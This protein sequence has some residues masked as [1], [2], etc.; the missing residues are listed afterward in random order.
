MSSSITEGVFHV[1]LLAF[2]AL[3][4]LVT[5]LDIFAGIQ[6]NFTC[7][8]TIIN[9]AFYVLYNDYILLYQESQLI[10]K[11]NLRITETSNQL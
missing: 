8:S 2:T 4:K 9:L 10:S 7:F 11:L 3:E 5:I 1:I 6:L